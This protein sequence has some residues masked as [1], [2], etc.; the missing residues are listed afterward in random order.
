MSRLHA[1][2]FLWHRRAMGEAAT[3]IIFEGFQKCTNVVL[4]GTHV[5]A[6]GVE[7][8]FAWQAQHFR[9]VVCVFFA[10]C[11]VRAVSSGDNVQIAW[12][13]GDIASVSF[14]MAGAVFGADPLCV[15]CCFAW[16]AQY[17]G[18]S[19]LYTLH[20]TLYSGHSTLHT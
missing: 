7:I 14:C 10:T 18:H 17:L 16:Q 4:R 15:E 3:P 13:A 8:R 20:S 12:Q 2:A 6:N 5:S 9:H 19:T 11:N 1:L